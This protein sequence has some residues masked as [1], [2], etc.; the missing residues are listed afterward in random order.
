[1]AVKSILCTYSGDPDK[2]SGLA[3]TCGDPGFG[4]GHAV[5]G[6]QGAHHTADRRG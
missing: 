2:G 4:G 6:N 5:S 3:Q 1:M